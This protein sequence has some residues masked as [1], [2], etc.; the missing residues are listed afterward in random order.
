MVTDAGVVGNIPADSGYSSLSYENWYGYYTVN[1]VNNNFMNSTLLGL[2]YGTRELYASDSFFGVNAIVPFIDT[3]EMWK[4]MFDLT[5]VHPDLGTSITAYPDGKETNLQKIYDIRNVSKSQQTKSEKIKEAEKLNFIYYV[6]CCLQNKTE[7]PEESFFACITGW[8]ADTDNP[9][10]GFNNE[11]LVYRYRW[12]RIGVNLNSSNLTDFSNFTLPESDTW[13]YTGEESSEDDF[14]TFAI[15]LNERKNQAD[16][17]TTGYY[18]PGWYA[19]NMMEQLFENVSYRPIANRTGDLTES[20]AD[21]GECFHIV[22]M[23]KVPF[24]KL[25]KEAANYFTA[26]TD[27]EKLS[28]IMNAANGKYLYY[29][30]LANITDGPCGTNEQ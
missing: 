26:V 9:Q 5:P 2:E 23:T 16:S 14:T 6:L 1:D 10:I 22:K 15:N 12:K 24:I 17:P 13:I 21:T 7:E 20:Q 25:I 29:F 3:P 8:E 18:A 19:A 30:E 28:E 4:N 11:S 27:T